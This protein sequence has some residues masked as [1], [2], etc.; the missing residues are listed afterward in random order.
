MDIKNY[1]N[2]QFEVSKAASFFDV[3]DPSSGEVIAKTPLSL[4]SELER[5]V[6]SAKKAFNT[7]RST[8]AVDRVQPLYRLKNL[9]ERD[10]DRI[11][12]ILVREHGKTFSEAKGDLLRGIQ[13]CEVACGIPSLQMGKFS[14]NVAKGIDSYSMRRPLGVFAG[15]N[16]FNFPAM[17]PFWFWPFAV[18]TG[19]TFIMKPS[20]RVPMTQEYIFELINECG[21][22]P[23]VISLVN[24][25]KEI[26]E[27]ILNHPDIVGVSFVGST[28]VAKI[29]YESGRA[30]NKRVQALG[31]A[32]NF[33][34]MTDKASVDKSVRAMVDSCYGCAGERCLAG[35]VL[36]GVGNCYD[37]LKREVIK[38]AESVVVGPGMDKGTTMGP[39]IS[40]MAMDR[41]NNDIDTAVKEGAEIV[42]DG[43]LKVP[44]GE[45]YYLGP[46]VIEN[47]KPG[48]LMATKEIFGPVIGLMKV[49]HL[50]EAVN[51]IN[52]SS[53]ANTC[54]IFSNDGM[55]AQQFIDS[56][57]PS[58]V[59]VNLG[60]PAPMAFFSF[61]GSKE[62]FF[63]DIKVHGQSS[64][65]FFTEEHTVMQRWF[66]LDA[67]QELNP[68]WNK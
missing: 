65:E 20:E 48:T 22:P 55:E 19:N 35:S 52:S 25:G 42:F 40:K 64:I 17:V 10:S 44:N 58:M 21:F 54:S 34:V 53:Y 27:G 43:R 51:L 39:V 50:S 4:P 28:E 31:G 67:N 38:N 24:G 9:L 7:W 16:P 60:V 41:I 62:S 13:M 11:S 26:V 32:K 18:A 29:V 12:E 36:V 30:N 66:N 15:I 5:A 59:G 56:V 37:E 45:G 33:L 6:A 14:N 46:V 49:G 3:H 23:G 2:G 63:G 61:G 1:I 47:I 57:H 68:H 8:P